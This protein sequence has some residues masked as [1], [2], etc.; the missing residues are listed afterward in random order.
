MLLLSSHSQLINIGSGIPTTWETV[1]ES[2]IRVVGETPY[3]N[4]VAIKHIHKGIGMLDVG[5]IHKGIGT[6]IRELRKE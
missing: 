5:H 6:W 1:I 3:G 2:F 4:V